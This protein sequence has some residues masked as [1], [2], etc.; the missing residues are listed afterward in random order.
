MKH[1]NSTDKYICSKIPNEV[2]K[3][4]VKQ[5]HCS[6]EANFEHECVQS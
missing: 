2:I 6:L 3:L 5:A 1:F 4:K